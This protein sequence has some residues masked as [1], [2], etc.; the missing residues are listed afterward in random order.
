M[1]TIRSLLSAA[2]LIWP[3]AGAAQEH[4]MG[5]NHA[6]AMV[7]ATE[8]GQGAFAAIGEIVGLLRAD[9]ATD[10]TR[11]DIEALR[12]HLIDMDNV[13]L[14]SEVA[15]AEVPE[16]AVFSVTSDDANVVASIQRMVTAHAATMDDPSGWRYGAVATATGADLTVTGDAA[17]IR[18]LGFIGAMTVGMHHQAH[19]WAIATGAA[20]HQ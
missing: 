8:P 1:Q 9:P 15:V 14:R 2:F 12:Q 4:H 18:A 10:W 11:V 6:G 13:T 20:P 16:G 5:M 3:L 17:Q 19:H 7:S